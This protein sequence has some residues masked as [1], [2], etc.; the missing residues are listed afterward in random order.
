MT[1][2]SKFVPQKKKRYLVTD[3]CFWEKLT[4]EEKKAYNPY[5]T[6][7]APHSVE[8]VDVETGTVVHLPSGSVV[9]VIEYHEQKE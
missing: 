8:L 3:Q 6:T 2:A 9:E 4:D 1:L 5:D 7:R